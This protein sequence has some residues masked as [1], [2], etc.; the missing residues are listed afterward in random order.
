MTTLLFLT[1]SI[2]CVSCF[3]TGTTGRQ[4]G[5]TRLYSDGIEKPS[6]SFVEGASFDSRMEEIEAM[7]GDS[8]F[9]MDDDDDVDDDAT[10]SPPAEEQAMPSIPFSSALGSILEQAEAAAEDG[11]SDDVPRCATDG[12]GPIPRESRNVQVK[13]G[14][15]W[16]GIVDENAHLG[17]D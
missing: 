16:D 14:E 7:G 10:V 8:F 11:A 9:L 15:L 17:F 13:P 1:T 3:A 4:F 2:A 12:K 5:T 6:H